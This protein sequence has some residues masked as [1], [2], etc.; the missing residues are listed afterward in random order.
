MFDKKPRNE[1]QLMPGEVLF[2][3][4][5]PGDVMYFIRKGKI[6]ISIGEEDMETVLKIL[7]EG[8]FFG[9]M[10]VIDGSPRSASATAIEETELLVI[11]K[12]S[13]DDK[14]RE[15]PL[16]EYVLTE[17]TTRVRT[18]DQQL[19]YLSI[20]SD[21]ERIIHYILSQARRQGSPMDEGVRLNNITANDIAYITGVEGAKVVEYLGRLE[22][23]QLIQV[24]DDTLTVRSI[25]SL[26]EYIQF[27]KLR[28]KFKS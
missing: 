28:D 1:R 23:V 20:K 19:K 25:P 21:E 24:E 15:N 14:M 8:D 5:D 27:V 11:T 2:R 6:K 4:G 3:E 7:K 26:E 18:L 13:F 9:E 12:D 17:L 10:A 16:I 22:S